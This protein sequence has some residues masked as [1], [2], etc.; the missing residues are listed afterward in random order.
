[1]SEER[2]CPKPLLGRVAGNHAISD[3]PSMRLLVAGIFQAETA[4]ELYQGDSESPGAIG[5]PHR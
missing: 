1:M 5:S 4:P 3:L 2:A